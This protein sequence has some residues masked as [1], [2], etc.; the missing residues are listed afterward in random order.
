MNLIQRELLEKLNAVFVLNKPVWSMLQHLNPGMFEHSAQMHPLLLVML[1]TAI[2]HA[3]LESLYYDNTKLE[4]VITSDYRPGDSLTHGL[5][6]CPAVDVRAKGSRR[7][8]YLLAGL[9]EVGFTRVSDIYSDGHIHADCAD[10]IDPVRWPPRVSWNPGD[11]GKK[12][13]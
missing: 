1:D 4:I 7:R 6:P 8:H 11:K 5:K 12:I 3:Q 13:P 9:R 10:L 2:S